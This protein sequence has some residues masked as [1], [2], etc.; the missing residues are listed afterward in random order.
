MALVVVS[1]WTLTAQHQLVSHVCCWLGD[2][3][4]KQTVGTGPRLLP[5]WDP[6]LWPG[7][8]P[9]DTFETQYLGL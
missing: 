5:Q 2:H 3:Q 7:V 9:G 1:I 8:V 6:S 4:W